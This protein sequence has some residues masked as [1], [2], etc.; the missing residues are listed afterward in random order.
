MFKKAIIQLYDLKDKYKDNT[1]ITESIDEV[2]QDLVIG[3]VAVTEI[4]TDLLEI[5]EK[6]TKCNIIQ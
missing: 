1:D 5:E 2:V 4:I 3:M 6:S